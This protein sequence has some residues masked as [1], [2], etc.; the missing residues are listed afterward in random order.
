MHNYE[1][2]HIFSFKDMTAPRPSYSVRQRERQRARLV[3]RIA[4]YRMPRRLALRQK[5]G[6]DV[7]D[8]YR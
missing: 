8:A 5:D 1:F 2:K 4:L 6:A 7:G 3:R